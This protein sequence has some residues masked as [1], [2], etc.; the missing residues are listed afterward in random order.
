MLS[1]DAVNLPYLWD[2]F[3]IEA[4]YDPPHFNRTMTTLHKLIE[5][6]VPEFLVSE[7]LCALED[8]ED[9]YDTYD[10][11]FD[12]YF[13]DFWNTDNNDRLSNFLI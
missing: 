12:E 6:G 13:N 5:H 7:L 8:V 1:D 4:P 10:E 2:D 9:A 3:L 11:L